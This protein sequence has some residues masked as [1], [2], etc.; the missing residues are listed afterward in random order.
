V[1]AIAIW[2]A[3]SCDRAATLNS[4]PEGEGSYEE[5]RGDPEEEREA[6]AHRNVEEVLPI[7]TATDSP[8]C[9]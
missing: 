5:D 4:N 1:K 6:P 7:A 3:G 9:R 2:L 8:P